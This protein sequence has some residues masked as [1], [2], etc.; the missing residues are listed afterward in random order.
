MAS[1]YTSLRDLGAVAISHRGEVDAVKRHLDI[2]HGYFD[3]WIYGFLENKKFNVEE[4]VEKLHR[5]FAMEVNELASYELSDF[6]R[7]SMRAGIISEIGNDKAGRVAFLVNTKRD[8]PQA[9]LRQEQRRSF[10][11]FVS[12][13]TRLREE[14]KRCQMVMLINQEGASLF[15]N[16]DMTFQGDI[17]LRISKFYPGGVDKMYICK[18]SRT[19][20]AIA[21]PIF[22]RL[23]GIVADRIQIIDEHDIKQ[24]VL[25]DLFDEEVLPVAFG[26]KNKCDDEEHWCAYADRVEKYYADLKRAVNERGLTVKDYELECLGIHPATAHEGSGAHGTAAATSHADTL[27]QSVRDFPAQLLSHEPSTNFAPGDPIWPKLL[28][29]SQASLQHIADA[30]QNLDSDLKSLKTCFTEGSYLLS[31][32]YHGADYGEAGAGMT[33]SWAKVV[34]PFPDSLALFFLDELLRW[35]T[36]VERSESGERYKILDSFV[37]GLKTTTERGVRGLDVS[38]RKWYVGI[39]YPLRALY[40]TLLVAIT[41]LNTVYFLAALVF[42][43]V[44][45]ADIIITMFFASF[46]KPGYVFPLSAVL[47]MV[48][49]QGASLCTRAADCILAVYHRN[50][51]PPFE[52]LGSYWGA[53]A[54]VSLFFVMFITQFVIFCVY[55]VNENPLRGLQ[56]SFATG[57]MS[58]LFVIVFMHVFF[59]TGL[60]ASPAARDADNRL[61]ALPFFLAFNFGNSSK[62]QHREPDARFMLRTSSYVICGIPL[63]VSMLFG[64]AFIISRMVSLYAANFASAVIAAYVVHYYSDALSNTLSGSLLRFTLW[65][66]VLAWC[67]VTFVLGFLHYKSSYGSSVIVVS[68]LNGVFVLLALACL[69]RSGQSWLLRVAYMI[70]IAYIFGCW[71]S[72]FPLVGWRI[73]L[74]CFAMMFHNALNI[75]FAPGTLT[76]IHAS[77]FLA[78]AVVLLGVSCTLLGWYG[79]TPTTTKPQSLASVLPTDAPL[80]MLDLYHRYPVCTLQMGQDNSLRVLDIALLNELVGART[81]DALNVDLN[82]W[83]GPRGVIYKGPVR[84][85]NGGDIPWEMHEFVLPAI[86]DTTVF[87]LRNRYAISCIVAMMNWVDA[88]ALF[89]LSIFMP[90]DW[91]DTVVFVMSFASRMIPFAT[92]VVVDD[93]RDFLHLRQSQMQ[94]TTLVTGSGVA[95]GVLSAAAAQAKTHAVVFSSPGLLHCSRKLGVRYDEYHRFVLS[96]GAYH[97]VLN[98]IGGQDSTISQR[99]PCG[100]TAFYCTRPQFFSEALLAACGDAEGRRHIPST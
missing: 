60:L 46:V 89:P 98:Y 52:R 78:A 80:S 27:L 55:A 75:T 90:Y 13:G 65:M 1:T 24:G 10:D 29:D 36:A 83:F 2:K 79:T 59:F 37:S 91:V 7:E 93:I 35:R 30:S 20:A 22:K 28:G 21:K 42:C 18:M 56:V 95:G 92:N 17:A 41:V 76:G 11:M 51:I 61:A 96:I 4:T 84:E 25:L 73:G 32:E 71:I 97:G 16:V 72:L 9:K 12:Y 68:T 86:T 67:Y 43:V 26:G 23:P 15:K 87:V 49:I 82:N 54:E 58:T 81:I 74:F 39:P 62:E 57:W 38:D 19:L 94:T 31:P 53:M 70:V 8:H 45:C 100:G 64:I 50:V 88:I 5:R 99:I 69:R 47:L 33:M 3:A 66:M 14:N 63:V 85:F 34:A 77:F 48:A 44:F 6:M 40:R